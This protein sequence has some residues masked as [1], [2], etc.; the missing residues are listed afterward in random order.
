MPAHNIL[1]QLQSL[2]AYSRLE[3]AA[4]A[5]L[6]NKEL[7]GHRYIDANHASAAIALT[8]P[9]A[10]NGN[11]GAIVTFTNYAA[12]VLTVVDAAGFGGGGNDT[13]TLAQGECCEI[14]SDGAKWFELHNEPA[15]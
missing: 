6:T 4:T 13:V 11:K 9:T 8:L 5:T 12:A 3:K 15:A 1:S 7:M 10:G 14:H 2:V